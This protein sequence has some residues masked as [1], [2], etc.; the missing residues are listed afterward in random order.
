MGACGLIEEDEVPAGHVL[1]EEE[2]REY[3]APLPL[4]E[5]GCGQPD[6]ERLAVGEEV[7][8][9]I[10]I[11]W[12]ENPG[13]L[14][15]TVDDCDNIVLSWGTA[16][17]AYVLRLLASGEKSF[18]RV[19]A[20]S[21][22]EDFPGGA[23]ELATDAYGNIFGVAYASMVRLTPSGEDFPRGLFLPYRARFLRRD[24]DT[25]LFGGWN[26]YAR[27][28]VA[29]GEFVWK[30]HGFEDDE[31]EVRMMDAAPVNEDSF[32]RAMY[33]ASTEPPIWV[34]RVTPSKPPEAAL[35]SEIEVLWS[36]GRPSNLSR[37]E[38]NSA[39]ETF[40]VAVSF[41]E[42][43]DSS[44]EWPSRGLI[45]KPPPCDEVQDVLFHPDGSMLS[46]WA[47]R[48]NDALKL[49]AW[50]P[51]EETP[52][53][54]AQGEL[55]PPAARLASVALRSDGAA[56]VSAFSGDGLGIRIVVVEMP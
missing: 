2:E 10:E 9:E 47:D 54:F 28:D 12:P 46:L 52:T 23:Y 17:N 27:L 20:P 21:D 16:G 6:L 42:P 37:I 55:P 4:G 19:V 30:S 3:N 49:L 50:A 24:G 51:D 35:D 31:R 11:E 36:Y 29:S 1:T 38:V 53:E 32:L 22:S 13:R 15:S 18:Y 48:E 56:V 33:G 14:T 5:G 26:E 45:H 40:G 44:L 43:C 41:V 34:E 39:Q 25:F 7:F 8:V